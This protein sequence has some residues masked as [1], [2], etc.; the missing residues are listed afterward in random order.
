MFARPA[1]RGL[2]AR[3]L[4]RVAAPVPRVFDARGRWA[5]YQAN[6]LRVGNIVQKAGQLLEVTKHSYTQGQARASGNVQVEYRDL[7]T[8]GKLQER[9][10]PSDK[11][12]RA[13]LDAEVR[14]VV[15]SE[16][17]GIPPTR[18]SRNDPDARRT[19]G[20]RTLPPA[21]ARPSNATDPDPPPIE[22]DRSIEHPHAPSQ[23]Y[24]YLYT[25]GENVVAMHPTTFEQTE[26]PSAA[27]GAAKRFLAEG[28]KVR[29]LLFEGERI[30]AALPDE[31]ELVVTEAAPSV[32]GES[33]DAQ[34]KPATTETGASV[35]VPTF[36]EAGDKIVV[37]TATGDFLRRVR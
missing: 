13:A 10:S 6:E 7:R 37:A 16:R 20:V 31:V 29:V 4:E 5:T 35:R 32:K 22:S 25:D 33:K 11:V 18:E 36:V 21:N 24:D 34:F 14:P 19:P 28:S 15:R 3:G 26:I 17:D 9:L 1:L 2:A 8:G 12:E 30:S 23:E 27:L